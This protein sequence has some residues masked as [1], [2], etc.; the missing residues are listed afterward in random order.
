MAQWE[1]TTESMGVHSFDW[2]NDP[3]QVDPE[4][5]MHYVETY[6]IHVNAATY[7][8]FPRKLF[9]DWVR[10]E[11]VKSPDDLMLIYTILA[12]GSIFSSRTE[13]KHEGSLFGKI[14]RFA[15]E[16]NHGNYSLQ[17]IQ[18]R[19]LLA[20][21]HF[22]MGDAH[23]AWD[24]G[25]MG[26]RVVSGLR[27]NVEDGIT[28]IGDDDILD[29]GLNR[30]ALE[31]CRRRTFWS[32]YIMDVSLQACRFYLDQAERN[33]ALQR[34]LLGP[35]LRYSQRGFFCPPAMQRRSLRA[36]GSGGNAVF[37]QRADGPK[38]MSQR[39]LF[40]TRTHGVL[41]T[42]CINMGG[43]AGE[44]IPIASSIRRK[45]LGRPRGFSHHHPPTASFM[46]IKPTGVFA[47]QCIQHER[48]HRKRLHGH[49]H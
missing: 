5:T 9:L 17:L 11:T 16:R 26:F 24:Y 40:E 12:M 3:Y 32:A 30:H 42:D 14:A 7:R 2:A 8:L 47:V 27:L 43:C 38:I 20:F 49:L 23:K 36:A 6:F 18:S 4:I 1:S 22:S 33:L 37:R 15:V 48:Q 44:Y 46:E 19:L 13:R 35:S 29:Y 10:G 28:D 31:E 45:I 21:Y 25:G 39:E 41:C 34:I